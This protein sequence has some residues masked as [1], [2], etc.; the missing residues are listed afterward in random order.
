[1]LATLAA[2]VAVPSCSSDEDARRRAANLAEGCVLNSDCT[3][4]LVCAFGRCHEQC[5]ESRDCPAGDRCV[6]S[7]GGAHVCQLD[8]EKS[9]LAKSQCQGSQSCAVD[10][11]CRDECTSP[12]D[13]VS[14]QQCADG[15]CADPEELDDTGKLPVV[16]KD[17]GSGGAG[18]S[19]GSGGTGAAGGSGGSGGVGA[20]GGSS[21]AGGGGGII[22]AGTSPEAFWEKAPADSRTIAH[23]V[24]APGA[25]VVLRSAGILSG[26]EIVRIDTGTKAEKILLDRS[27][28]TCGGLAADDTNVYF[29]LSDVTGQTTPEVHFLPLAGGTPT[30]WAAS[31]TAAQVLFGT[32]THLVWSNGKQIV[33]AAKSDKNPIMIASAS[34]LSL[35]GAG[36]SHAWYVKEYTSGEYRVYRVVFQAFKPS[37]SMAQGARPDDRGAV[38]GDTL[39]WAR[40]DTGAADGKVVR[41]DALPSPSEKTLLAPVRPTNLVLDTSSAF[42]YSRAPDA[43]FYRAPKNG[44][45]VTAL[46]QS[47]SIAWLIGVDASHLYYFEDGSSKLWRLVK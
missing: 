45:P 37:D 15:V 1:V 10:G 27:D 21:G 32:N 38:A 23:A 8:D 35:L 30:K 34:A 14:G 7:V 40:Q 22:D 29:G 24:L 42:F 36:P 25:V 41:L 46:G 4:P 43:T 17:A 16:D 47:S 20:S 5:A 28:G 39:F 2:L 44:G 31:L 6:L 11:E 19:G 18:G 13:C 33:F 9:C 26:C 12:S 3:D